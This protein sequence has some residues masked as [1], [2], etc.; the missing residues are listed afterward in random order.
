MTDGRQLALDKV[1]ETYAAAPMLQELAARSPLVRPSGPLNAPLMLVGE[2]PGRDEVIQGAP[3]VGAAGTLLDHLLERA[4]IIRRYAYVTNTVLYRPPGNRTPY[5]FEIQVSAPRLQ[6]EIMI[7]RPEIVIAL[8][9][10]AARAIGPRNVP[11]TELR[12]KWHALNTGDHHCD[13]LV[14]WHPAAAL[15]DRTAEQELAKHLITV[16]N[17][18]AA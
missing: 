18:E 17:R 8:G 11:V 10:T 16:M 1:L 3:F 13:L 4:G 7:V 6:Q 15:R 2:A 9:S 14:T 5:P 12:G